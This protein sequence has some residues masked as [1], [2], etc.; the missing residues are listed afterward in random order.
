MYRDEPYHFCRNNITK[1]F[2]IFS[3][4]QDKNLEL[5]SLTAEGEYS[6]K[7]FSIAQS[8]IVY[9]CFLMDLDMYFIALSD[10]NLIK[11]NSNDMEV[12]GSIEG[13]ISSIS[14]SPDED[15][16]VIITKNGLLLLLNR[17]FNVLKEFNICLTLSSSKI[18]WRND[19]AC[20]SVLCTSHEGSL[21]SVYSK[22]GRLESQSERMESL[23][24]L[25]WRPSGELAASIKKSP[26]KTE[27][28]FFERNSLQHG[29]FTISSD[30]VLHL[31]WNSDSSLL[32]LLR[33]G[34]D[35]SNF[36]QLWHRMNYHWYL[37]YVIEG[38]FFSF[39]FDP[40]DPF[41]LFT[42]STKSINEYEF[43]WETFRDLSGNSTVAVVDEKKLLITPFSYQNVPP[44]MCS[45]S[46]ATEKNALD[47]FFDSFGCLYSLFSGIVLKYSIP[48]KVDQS[49]PALLQS[50]EMDNSII[51]RQLITEKTNLVILCFDGK[52]DFLL[53]RSFDGS[54]SEIPLPFQAYRLHSIKNYSIVQAKNGQIYRICIAEQKVSELSGYGFPLCCPW[55]TS[56]SFTEDMEDSDYP[57]VSIYGLSKKGKVYLCEKLKFS[58]INSMIAHGSLLLLASLE[59][60][61]LFHSAKEDSAHVQYPLRSIERGSMIVTSNELNSSVIL[62]MPRG[63]IETI[64][65]R[66]LS[67]GLLIHFIEEKNYRDAFLIC[68][69]NRIDMN[70][71]VDINMKAFDCTSFVSQIHE[72]EYLNLFVTAL[73]DYNSIRKSYGEYSS[74]FSED[75]LTFDGI[76]VNLLCREIRASLENQKIKYA[77]TIM[78]TYVKQSPPDLE[79]ALSYIS[80]LKQ[81]NFSPSMIDKTL[82]YLIFLVDANQLFDIALGMYDFSLCLSIAQR[83]QKDP[84]EYIPFLE[85]LS[86]MTEN[87]QKFRINDH[88]KKYSKALEFLYFSVQEGF[89]S[90]SFLLEYVG[91]FKLYSQ[92]LRIATSK[93]V[94]Y[95]DF[96]ELYADFLLTEK[97]DFY[98]AGSC[99]KQCG[100]NEKAIECFVKSSSSCHEALLVAHEIQLDEKEIRA[101]VSMCKDVLVN[102]KMY[103]CAADLVMEYLKDVDMAVGILLDGHCWTKAKRI[104]FHNKRTDLIETLINPTFYQCNSNELI[105]RFIA[106]QARFI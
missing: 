12:L 8:D 59:H 44:P 61:L 79:S 95:N 77:E 42:L 9:A 81:E 30:D 50:Y 72:V 35:G 103:D 82:K 83:S 89:Q 104:S 93:D 18:S 100:K 85:E 101:I 11:I 23:E 64:Y 99:Y 57:S 94:F 31:D 55:M 74:I 4:N 105:Y 67:L 76:K 48:S 2:C 91:R 97:K 106:C 13:G 29:E 10:G 40:E 68:R 56:F 70:L 24:C 60:K 62:Q 80:L 37:K 17:D 7:V 84:K 52:E 25:S 102:D 36:L 19:C 92:F 96:L 6:H 87:I 53:I 41:L 88:L 5:K 78:T 39:S 58:S 54:C 47:V 45:H 69:K 86:A 15:A 63:N 75:S 20:F 33:K 27:V 26:H 14:W 34:R 1:E 28:V 46:I 16:L 49:S 66:N 90:A 32:G 51:S 65:P 38:D 73:C 43:C 71:L 98:L 22:D 3:F 21:I